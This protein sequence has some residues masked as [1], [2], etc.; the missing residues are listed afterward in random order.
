MS[1]PVP[2]RLPAGV[3][4][5]APACLAFREDQLVTIDATTGQRRVRPMWSAVCEPVPVDPGILRAVCFR[6]GRLV[7]AGRFDQGRLERGLFIA[8][9]LPRA[10]LQ[11]TY[12]SV[13][14][15]DGTLRSAHAW[16]DDDDVVPTDIPFAAW[17]EARVAELLG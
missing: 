8:R 15:E 1:L 2:G 5:I 12:T 6:D 9:E 13:A 7:F 17:V 11:Q 3:V 16:S 4:E 10:L 14:W